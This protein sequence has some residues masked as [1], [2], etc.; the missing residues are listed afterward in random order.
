MI[1]SIF[2][3]SILLCGVVIFGFAACTDLVNF[4]GVEK[5]LTENKITIYCG[6][7]LEKNRHKPIF[8]VNGNIFDQDSLASLNP[9]QIRSIEVLKGKEAFE[10]YGS[11][12]K[13]GVVE[14]NTDQERF[15]FLE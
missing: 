13:Y 7:P 14:V 4:S 12:A 1:R 11:A 6:I 3:Q 2:I 5:E 10:Q 9:D 15:T 8:V